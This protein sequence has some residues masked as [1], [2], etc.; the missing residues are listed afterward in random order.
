MTVV[1]RRLRQALSQLSDKVGRRMPRWPEGSWPESLQRSPH[2]VR[3]TAKDLI[4]NTA[5][6]AVS[7]G[8]EA[9]RASL[10]KVR[11]SSRR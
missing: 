4:K 3:A 10:R 2:R 7:F 5:K 1:A 8:R 11:G 9:A 6:T